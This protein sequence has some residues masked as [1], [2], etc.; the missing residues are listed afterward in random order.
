MVH[1]AVAPPRVEEILPLLRR[2]DILTHCFTGM[3]M[4]IVDDE[5]RLLEAARRAWDS[6][7]IMDIGHGSGSFSFA[8]TEALFAAGRRPD[9]I[10]SDIH[11]LSVRGPMFDMP[12]T[13]SKF[14][15]LDLSLADVIRAATIRPAEVLGLERDVGTLRPGAFAD[16]ALFELERGR[17]PFYDIHGEMREG[18]E[19]LRSTLT[20]LGGRPL[21]HLPEPPP[22][23]WIEPGPIWPD[24]FAERAAVY[25]EALVRDEGAPLPTGAAQPGTDRTRAARP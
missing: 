22:P 4:K 21:P 1:I 11:Q 6:G 23:P 20:I 25:R 2:G 12:T 18:D 17:F 13:L 9:V 15:A 16:I 3:S 19:L 14:L 5:G 7:V 8:T 24:A 10:S